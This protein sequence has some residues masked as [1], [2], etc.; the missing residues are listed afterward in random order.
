[1]KALIRDEYGP[2][3]VLRLEEVEAPRPAD[4]EVLVEVHA[5][6]MNPADWHMLT[7]D[8]WVV[9]LMSGGLFRPNAR[10]IGADVAGRVVAVGKKVTLFRPGDDVFGTALVGGFAELVCVKES[11][12]AARPE[13]MTVEQAAALPIA[14]VTALQGLRDHGGLTADHHVLINGA[15]GGIG[16]FAVQLAKYFGAEVTGVCSTKKVERVRDLGADHVID[17][18]REDFT[19]TGARYDLIFDT[20]AFRSIRET[21]R[22]LAPG[23]TY[24]LAGGS[25][26]SMKQAMRLNVWNKL[27]GGPKIRWFNAQSRTE[28]LAVLAELYEDDAVIPIVSGRFVMEDIPEAMRQLGEGHTYGKLVAT[29][30][31]AGSAAGVAA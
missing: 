10:I 11:K 3:D 23:G 1:M 22:A 28:D 25:W 5:T 2:P 27:V 16:T 26:D 12:L 24:V 19:Q 18:R 14:G 9:R 31:A 21:Y 29:M 6:S 15:G 4:D 20:A 8:I 30:A 17:Y 7:A 13:S